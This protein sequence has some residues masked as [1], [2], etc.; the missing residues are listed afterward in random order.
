MTDMNKAVEMV[1]LLILYQAAD[2]Q[3]QEVIRRVMS[4]VIDVVTSAEGG[5]ILFVDTEGDGE[6]NVHLIGDSSLTP[7]M[8]RSAQR[9]YDKVFGVPEDALPQ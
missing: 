9:V 3:D 5:G 2:E 4:D 1:D 7:L 8:L 6:M